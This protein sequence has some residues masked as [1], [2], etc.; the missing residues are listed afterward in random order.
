MKTLNGSNFDDWKESL[1][2]YL[3]IAQLDLALRVDAPAELT[4]ES[5]IAEKTYHEK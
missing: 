2:M 4:D 5:T 3:A 1:S